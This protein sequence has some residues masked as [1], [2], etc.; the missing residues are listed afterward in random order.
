MFEAPTL[1]RRHPFVDVMWVGHGWI[2]TKKIVDYVGDQD[3]WVDSISEV[4][5][6]AQ[7]Q[8]ACV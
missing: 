4:D 8:A 7:F 2:P 1:M 5:P 6:R 3:W